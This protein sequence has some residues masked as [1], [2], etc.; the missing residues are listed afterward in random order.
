M[1]TDWPS[2][3][4]GK[5]GAFGLI[6]STPVWFTPSDYMLWFWQAGGLELAQDLY[7][8]YGLVWYPHSVVKPL[9]SLG[10]SSVCNLVA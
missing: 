8:K 9:Y 1:A 4:E 6:T 10:F 2:Y 3:W 5:N 7:G